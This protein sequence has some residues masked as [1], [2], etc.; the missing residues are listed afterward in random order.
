MDGAL[1]DVIE[2]VD[3]APAR[4]RGRRTESVLDFEGI[5]NFRDYG[6]YAVAGGGRLRSGLLYRSGQHIDATAGDLERIAAL[7]LRTVID[8]RGESERRDFPC[9]RP[10]GFDASILF[11]DG[12]TA[13]GGA[14]HL[15]ASVEIGSAAEA[16]AAMRLLY[17]TMPFRPRLVEALRLYFRALAERDGRSLLHCFAGK[18]RTGLAAALL[19]SVL[20]VH[21]DDVMFDYLL[22]N[23]AGNIERR[24]AAGAPAIRAR[25]G[26][27]LSDEALCVL[28]SVDA[29]YLNAAFSAIRGRYG[30]VDAYAHDVLGVDEEMGKAL[31]HR[32]LD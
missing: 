7:G 15:Q 30:G 27:H 1:M 19:H 12:E 4:R 18:D 3:P 14:P 10:D 8:L 25:R 2:P 29:A 5:H 6:G 26:E 16:H 11:A 28:M 23:R 17:E 24:I 9:A 22:T 13:G 32:L 20:G 21:A 31:R